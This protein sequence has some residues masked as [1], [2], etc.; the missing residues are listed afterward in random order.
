[1]SEHPYSADW[2]VRIIRTVGKAFEFAEKCLP[3]GWE[4][5]YAN[6]ARSSAAASLT[7]PHAMP[8]IGDSAIELV[9][10]VNDDTSIDTLLMNEQR[11]SKQETARLHWMAEVAVRFQWES[12]LAFRNVYQALGCDRLK[13]LSQRYGALAAA[14]VVPY[15]FIE[16]PKEEA[17]TNLARIRKERG[18][19]Q[20]ALSQASGV[21]LRS[22]QQYEQRKKDI[23]HAQVR[24]VLGLAKALGC[25]IEELL[26]PDLG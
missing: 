5:F 19:S 3:G 21:S 10:D 14:D 23:N 12:G 8:A 4:S 11:L 2:L 22:V 24:S 9:L 16:A 15:L 20:Q 17:S 13:E 1:M 26:E 7:G 6:F 18:F 25:T